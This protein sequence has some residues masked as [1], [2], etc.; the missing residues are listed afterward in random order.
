MA[1]CRLLLTDGDE[2]LLTSGDLLLLTDTSCESL[3][4]VV[5]C[6]TLTVEDVATITLTVEDCT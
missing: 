5:G 4:A 6:L 1:N 2:L 3:T